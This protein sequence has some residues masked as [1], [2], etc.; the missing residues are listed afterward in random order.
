MRGWHRKIK[1]SMEVIFFSVQI[2]SLFP[3]H[4]G[5]SYPY[6][7]ARINI[8]GKTILYKLVSCFSVL[9]FLQG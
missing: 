6:L 5:I 9:L 3:E 2:V 8:R 7:D 1:S 4:S